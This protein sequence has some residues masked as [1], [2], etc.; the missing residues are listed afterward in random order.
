MPRPFRTPRPNGFSLVELAVVLAVIGLIAGGIMGGRSLIR[1]AELNEIISSFNKYKTASNRFVLQ[2]K[3]LPGDFPDA[4]EYWGEAASGTA[5][6]TTVGTG[7]ATCNGNA[8]GTLRNI[9][10]SSE[11]FRIWQHLANAGLIQGQYSGVP[12]EGVYSGA[13]A[14]TAN[15]PT[16]RRDGGLWF[17]W[18]WGVYTANSNYFALDYGNSLV[19]GAYNP[20]NWP[21]SALLRG[22][23]AYSIDTKID[24]GK[25]GTGIA[26]GSY[27]TNCTTASSQ[28][29]YA[30]DYKQSEARRI[31]LLIF[32]RAIK[33]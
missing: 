20:G 8:D 16:T 1:T 28:T 11:A 27:L 26:I 31:C 30:A 19:A 12:T 24:D 15:V 13:G 10:T 14:S 9:T 5:C 18:Y 17:V 29:D 23:E 25:P 4:T 7:T 22:S 6:A 3:F 21:N 2:Y 33:L 32:P